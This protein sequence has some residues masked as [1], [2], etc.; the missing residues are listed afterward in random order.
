MGICQCRSVLFYSLGDPLSK[1]VIQLASERLLKHPICSDACLKRLYK[2]KILHVMD[3]NRYKYSLNINEC[4][5][6]GPISLVL[7]LGE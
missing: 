3:E 4:K 2:I 5:R 7:L 1:C 6:H